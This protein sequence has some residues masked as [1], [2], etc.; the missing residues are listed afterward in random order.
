[1]S[2][3]RLSSRVSADCFCRRA[4]DSHQSNEAGKGLPGFILVRT[5]AQQLR[6]RVLIYLFPPLGLA[7]F[8]IRG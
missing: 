8:G 3:W 2:H 4:T 1:M 6:V 7:S 5:L